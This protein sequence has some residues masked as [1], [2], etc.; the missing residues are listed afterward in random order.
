MNCH[1]LSG[2]ELYNR[3][4][5]G[6]KSKGTG[7]NHFASKILQSKIRIKRPIIFICN[8]SYVKSLKEL[9]KRALVFNFKK[10]E[11]SK[12]M[13]RLYEICVKERLLIDQDTLLRVCEQNDNDIRGCLNMLDFLARKKSNKSLKDDIFLAKKEMTKNY[14]DVIEDLI[15]I[16]KANNNT[17]QTTSFQKKPKFNIISYCFLNLHRNTEYSILSEG[18]FCNYSKIKQV[19][20]NLKK[21]NDFLESLVFSDTL[22]KSVLKNQ[23]FELKRYANLVAVQAHLSIATTEKFKIEFPRQNFEVQKSKKSIMQLY[24]GLTDALVAKQRPY[25]SKYTFPIQ[26]TTYLYQTIQPRIDST[27]LNAREKESLDSAGFIMIDFG[28]ELAQHQTDVLNR[29]GEVRTHSWTRPQLEKLILFDGVAI[30]HR[31]N[32]KLHLLLQSRF[33][34]L[35]AQRSAKLVKDELQDFLKP[36]AMEIVP[37][38]QIEEDLAGSMEVLEVTKKSKKRKERS[39]TD[40]SAGFLYKYKEGF[41]N[42][43]KYDLKMD[44]FFKSFNPKA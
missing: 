9:R 24:E 43:V 38:V 6:Q 1:V 26:Y 36:G 44:F 41:S 30:E 21:V 28:I 42:A 13:K 19:E 2:I 25:Y 23:H 15:H 33:G 12:L 8:D 39:E 27:I 34:Y 40:P 14:F 4:D 3:N 22:F 32:E 7:M 31:F 5:S 18:L 17:N 29:Q 10:P 16:D 11:T 37:T 20:S 35:K